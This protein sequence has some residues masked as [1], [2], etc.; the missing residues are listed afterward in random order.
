MSL[1]AR[2]VSIKIPSVGPEIVGSVKV[3]KSD[4]KTA[5]VSWSKSSSS[6]NNYE[7]RYFDSTDI[8]YE[9]VITKSEEYVLE[10]LAPDTE[11][12]VQVSTVPLWNNYY[13]FIAALW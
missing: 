11:Y 7:L 4:A 3:V 13:F 5:H 2:T 6:V 8:Q 1:C 10:K 12:T 9:N